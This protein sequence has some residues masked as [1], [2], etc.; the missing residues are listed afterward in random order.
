MVRSLVSKDDVVES[1]VR[2]SGPGGQNVNKV[3][4]CVV[5]HHKPTGIIIKCQKNRSQFLNREEAWKLLNKAVEDR[6]IKE[7]R[8]WRSAIEKKKRQT[9][10]KSKAAKERMLEEKKKRGLKKQNRSKR[11]ME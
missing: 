4:S 2:S 11:G 5:L 10:K 9:R 6:Q 7:H 8:A 1:F 3:S